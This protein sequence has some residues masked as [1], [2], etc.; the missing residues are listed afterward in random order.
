MFEQTGT[1]AHQEH[2][3]PMYDPAG[4]HKN[5]TVLMLIKTWIIN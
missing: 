3:T 4:K 5:T 1:D 2:K